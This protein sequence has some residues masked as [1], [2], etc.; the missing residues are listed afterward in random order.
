MKELMALKRLGRGS[1][2]AEELG[3]KDCVARCVSYLF[4]KLYCRLRG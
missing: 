1:D 4:K 2:E 3:W